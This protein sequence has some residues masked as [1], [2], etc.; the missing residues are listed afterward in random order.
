[1][2]GEQTAQLLRQRGIPTGET[3][4]VTP[5]IWQGVERPV[6]VVKHPL[7][8]LNRFNSFHLEAG[9]FCVMLSR[10]Q[11][12]CIVVGRE[13]IGLRLVEHRHAC[14]ERPFGGEDVEW[15]GW[16]AHSLL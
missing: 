11:L 13:S 6:M 12:G 10:Q 7:S 3:H 14:G 9:R 2:S 4:V 8:G 16:Q 1:M 15:S 5:E